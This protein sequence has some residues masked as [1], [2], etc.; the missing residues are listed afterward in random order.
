M[1]LCR[2][3][4]FMM[5]LKLLMSFLALVLVCR[6]ILIMILDSS[7]VMR[8]YGRLLRVKMLRRIILVCRHIGV[9]VTFP[10][11]VVFVLFP[12]IPRWSGRLRF[13]WYL[14]F[15]ILGRGST[16]LVRGMVALMRIVRV[17]GAWVVSPFGRRNARI[18]LVWVVGC[19]IGMTCRL[20]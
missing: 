4:W 2:R 12:R 3:K 5:L 15:L 20:G 18:V 17:S 13:G 19:L 1:L 11:W 9:V 6:V 7:I 14:W 10:S 16:V 8:K